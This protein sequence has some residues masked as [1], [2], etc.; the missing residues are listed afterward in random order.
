MHTFLPGN[1]PTGA[2]LAVRPPVTPPGS[3]LRAPVP[4][5]GWLSGASSTSVTSG[6]HHI[7]GDTHLS[8][9]LA[10]TQALG[11]NICGKNKTFPPAT[12][13]WATGEQSSPNSAP[14]GCHI[15]QFSAIFC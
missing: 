1:Y 3:Q 11:W 7:T 6:G 15:M 10:G 4:V 14:T 2:C 9:V 13:C 12:D 8:V 5:T